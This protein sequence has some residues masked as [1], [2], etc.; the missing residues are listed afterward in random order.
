MPL[1]AIM[2][3]ITIAKAFAGTSRVGASQEMVSIGV[4]NIIGSFFSSMTVTG[5][6]SRTTVNHSSG[7]QSPLGGLITGVMVLL[8]LQFLTPYFYFIP[9]A[10]LGAVIVCAV[11]NMVEFSV[12]Y[13]MWRTKSN[14]L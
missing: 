3:H 12:L 7:V 5:S 11:M 2:E 1:L 4:A 14:I 8:S 6:F 13:P 9:K 10:S